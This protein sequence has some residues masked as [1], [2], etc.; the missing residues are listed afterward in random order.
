MKTLG[1]IV[2]YNPF[3]Y[4][5]KLHLEKSK[6]KTGADYVV[7][8]MSGNYTQRGEVAIY[9]KYTRAKCAIDM[10]VNLVIELPLIYSISS[11]EH[12]SYGAV[13]ILDSMGEVDYLAF[14]SENLNEKEL[15][16]AYKKTLTNDFDEKLRAF[17]SNGNSYAKAK[18]LALGY[19]MNSNEI[20]AFNYIKAIEQL[21]SNIK[22]VT[23]KRE[24]SSYLSDKTEGK[25]SSAKSIRQLI[26]SKKEYSYYVPSEVYETIKDKR[27]LSNN[28]ITDM[29]IYSA[30]T[31]ELDDI[32][33][34]NE[35]LD[36]L[37]KKAAYKA[38]SYEELIELLVSKRY[39]RTRIQRLLLYVLL[40]ITND[41]RNY[42]YNNPYIKPLA[43][44]N[45]GRELLN[46][47]KGK[48]K[49]P[50]IQPNS[51]DKINEQELFASN[52]YYYI[53]KQNRF[54]ELKKNLYYKR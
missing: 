49:L 7:A 38:N 18:E 50:I 35:G 36:S 12:F 10:G 8:I 14:G 15:I 42:L 51:S 46:A 26:L 28:D 31:N 45:K 41:K 52:L 1:I 43:F 13:N 37:L 23:I 30:L 29:I 34:A 25:V 53:S 32:Y 54:S 48:A 44:D 5:H 16:K 3:H 9:D 47:I 39:P 11:A 20:L 21:G 19:K 27:A 6:K 40:G 22:P 24:N 2:E 17:I 4:G 33:M